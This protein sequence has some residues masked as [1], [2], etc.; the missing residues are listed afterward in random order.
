MTRLK[1][2]F[3]KRGFKLE[4]DYDHM[5]YYLNGKSFMDRGYVLLFGVQV[6]RE[7]AQLIRMLNIGTEVYSI[8]RDGSIDFDFV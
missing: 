7:Q 4:C 6:I 5:P 3:K 8:Q 1:K 2:E